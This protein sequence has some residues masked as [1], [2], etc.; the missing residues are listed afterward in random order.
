M[1]NETN[2]IYGRN[3][4]SEALESEVE[5]DKILILKNIEGSGKKIFAVAKDKGIPIQGVDRSV[6]DRVCGS[7]GHQG[8]AAYASRFAYCTVDD[9]LRV[10]EG[11]NENPF[12]LILDGI[13]DPHNLGAI[14]RSAEGVGAHGIIIPK[15]RAVAVTD[16]AIKSSA[17][18]AL[19]MA[20]A[21]VSNIASEMDVLKTRGLWL[22]GL[23]REGEDY[24][25]TAYE[26]GIALAIGSEGRGLSRLVKERC[27]FLLSIPMRGKVTS[28]NA[29]NAA[30][31]A[32]FEVGRHI[33]AQ[34]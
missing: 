27:D 30:A 31:I 11:R 24:R 18:A 19:H 25:E 26:G 8:V 13:E 2:L 12:V 34:D 21:R 14:M 33:F 7:G 32:M 15:R 3:A 17:G 16:V 1:G 4:V 9:I 10:A 23:D 28:L 29:S 5:I 22:Y 6:L 20:V